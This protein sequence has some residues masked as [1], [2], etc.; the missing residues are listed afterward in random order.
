MIITKVQINSLELTPTNG[1]YIQ[2][3][4][5]LGFTA[6]YGKADTITR[7]GQTLG[8]PFYTGKKLAI[9]LVCGNKNLTSHLWAR[10]ALIQ[11]LGQKQGILY[12]TRGNGVVLSIEGIFSTL[13]NDIDVD[14]LEYS[15]LSFT[16][17]TETP[18]LTGSF[19]N[20]QLGLAKG[21][22]AASPLTVPVNLTNGATLSFDVVNSGNTF[23]YPVIELV[24][25]LTTVIVI[26]NLTTNQIMSFA[27]TISSPRIVTIDTKYQ[28]AID[29]LGNNKRSL[30]TGKMIQLKAGTNKL[31]LE[32]GNTGDVG[33]A[34]IKYNHAYL[35]L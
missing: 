28:T 14:A 12:L 25:N 21:G 6:K 32:T 31:K 18:Y 17:E 15:E 34:Q 3:V 9:R 29:D 19:I 7:D 4:N 2:S 26:S 10:D 8:T 35:S 11:E 5:D 27:Q 33:F 23:V 22:G 20:Q 1:Y 13:D 16:I 24:G 30:L